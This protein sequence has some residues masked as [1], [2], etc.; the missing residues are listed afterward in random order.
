MAVKTPNQKRKYAALNK[1]LCKYVSLVQSLYNNVSYEAAKIAVASD[2]Q[3]NSD[4]EFRFKDYPNLKNQANDLM[5]FFCND[6]NVLI[7]SGTSDEWKQ[8]NLIQ[9]LLAKDVLKSYGIHRFGEKVKVYYQPNNDAMKAFQ[10]RRDNGMT[11]SQKIWN[12][13]YNLKRELEYAIS[14]AI[15]KGVSATTLSKRISKYLWDFPKLQKDYKELF[16][17]AV[18]CKDCEY[19]SIRLAR[20][21]INMAYRTAE[22]TRWSQMDF[23]KGYEIKLSGSHPK[24]DMCDELAGVYP[25]SFKWT[26]WHPN[27]LCYVVP[28]VMS[29][30]E[31][32][33][34]KGQMITD[35]PENF[36]EWIRNN[37][38]RISGWKTL[39]YFI[40]ENIDIVSDIL[41][42][43]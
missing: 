29:E 35:M 13:S 2:Y 8:S 40:E 3:P 24:E 18:D 10:T 38:E 9:D 16:G 6:L 34:G 30:D 33:G 23:I 15:E 37:V 36:K 14:S 21:E 43:G 31:F 11:V 20:S 22:Q 39:P 25:K 19:R 26:G 7:Y 12:Q 1:R 28:I 41:V 32:W 5:R 27:D 4:K 42:Q 17:K